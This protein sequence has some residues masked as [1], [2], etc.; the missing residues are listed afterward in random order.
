MKRALGWVA[1]LTIAVAVLAVAVFGDTE[2]P[3]N[4]ER[5]LNLADRIACPVCDGQS[6]AESNV[7]SAQAIRSEIRRRIDQG[8]T[9]DEILD[10]VLAGFSEDLSLTPKS[11]GVEGVVWIAPVVALIAG[12]AGLAFVFRR[13][14]SEVPSRATAEDRRLV[15]SARRSSGSPAAGDDPG[16]PRTRGDES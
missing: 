1:M 10:G 6:A 7:A 15:E 14:S 16:D 13:W 4:A 5:A 8:Q 9:D 3:T 11:G 12:L 2:E